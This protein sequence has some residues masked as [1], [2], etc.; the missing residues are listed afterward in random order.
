[1]TDAG[2]T[3]AQVRSLMAAA[4]PVAEDAFAVSWTDELWQEECRKI[5]VSGGQLRVGRSPGPRNRPGRPWQLAALTAVA[6]GTA[7]ALFIASGPRTA[8]VQ[9]LSHLSVFSPAAGSIR[10][11]SGTGEPARLVLLAVARKAAHA[12]AATGRYWLINST[13]G[14]FRLVGP[15]DDRYMIL[16]RGSTKWWQ[17]RST[18]DSSEEVLQ[19]LGT[20]LGSAADVA[21][22][23]RDGS[24]GT[25]DIG[26]AGGVADPQGFYDGAGGKARAAGGKPYA[27][28]SETPSSIL[29]YK[30]RPLTDLPADPMLLRAVLLQGYQQSGSD[31]GASSWIFQEGFRLLTEPVTPA[32]RSTVYR[33]LAG[34]P[35]V[36]NL[37]T[38][39]ALD[40]QAGSGIALTSRQPRCLISGTAWDSGSGSSPPTS[41]CMVQQRLIV[42]PLTG[43]PV[44][45]EL[46]YVKAPGDGKWPVPGGIFSYQILRH[47]GW[48]NSPPPAP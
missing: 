27:A 14:N 16:E 29:T 25:W 45:Q 4:N 5:L 26:S 42:N 44:A 11:G 22:W 15:S 38:V 33:V 8:P 2:D 24:P 28:F 7:A 23:R 13:Y 1:M 34:L 12:P 43:M 18:S 36:Q 30:G 41:S 37:G 20:K 17:P 19:R 35:G 10:A 40:G 6:A 46:S 9:R 32:V 47:T 3:V 31:G 39:R 48:E 21:P